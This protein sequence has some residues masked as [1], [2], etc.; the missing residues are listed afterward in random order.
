[1]SCWPYPKDAILRALCAR[2]RLVTGKSLDTF[3]P[4]NR[5]MTKHPKITKECPK[6]PQTFVQ[7][8]CEYK[9]LIPCGHSCLWSAIQSGNPVHSMKHTTARAQRDREREREKQKKRTK[10]EHTEAQPEAR[11]AGW[12]G[13]LPFN[14][15][16]A[17]RLKPWSSE[18]VWN[19][20]LP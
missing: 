20:G 4:E 6:L 13:G 11:T 8:P 18:C 16:I 17:E 7:S 14:D 2:R 1:M 3:S 15:A 19:S 5:I 9:L 12:K 10:S